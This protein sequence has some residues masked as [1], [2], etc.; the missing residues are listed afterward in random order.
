MVF[1]L[2]NFRA[3]LSLAV[4]DR[5]LRMQPSANSELTWSP[6]NLSSDREATPKTTDPGKIETAST[7]SRHNNERLTKTIRNDP[8]VASDA[9]VVR[10]IPDF[11]AFKELG[12]LAIESDARVLQEE[13]EPFGGVED[14]CNGDRPVIGDGPKFE[15][16]IGQKQQDNTRFFTL[17]RDCVYE[18]DA[19]PYTAPMGCWNTSKITNMRSAFFKF[20]E[21]NQLMAPS[22]PQ[23][24]AS[25]DT[26][27]VTDMA[28]MFEWSRD[29]NVPLDSWNTSSVKD[30]HGM[31]YH[32][33]A[34][35][36][37]IGS[38][39]TSSVR[40]MNQMFQGA[41]S[42]NQP[43][44]SW[45]VSRVTK[46]R[47]VF[48]DACAFNQPLGSWDVSSIDLRNHDLNRFLLDAKSFNQCLSEWSTKL[49]RRGWSYEMFLDT[50]CPY[51]LE[52]KDCETRDCESVSPGP[53][54]QGPE[55]QCYS[56]SGAFST[57]SRT[58]RLPF[59]VSVAAAVAPTVAS[60]LLV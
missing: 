24:I 21:S 32:A 42:F 44:G 29:F 27:S 28:F 14:E 19:C 41:S 59:F 49:P 2:S 1:F 57:W 31:F 58:N 60:L 45:N 54:C 37:P 11:D 10:N 4:T 46:A 15:L 50:S 52:S 13:E 6:T 23:G 22:V 18:N 36:Q 53:W 35:N 8:R 25:W 47:S 30:M 3:V 55:Q 16:H 5:G 51:Q 12:V 39:D 38:W 33:E 43:I 56:P 9:E 26:S 48:R 17:V 7:D 40:N 34:F 20:S